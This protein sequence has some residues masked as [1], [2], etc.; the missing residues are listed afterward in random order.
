M[1]TK[2]G[3]LFLAICVAVAFHIGGIFWLDHFSLSFQPQRFEN[4]VANREEA[5]EMW[6]RQQR[7]ELLAEIFSHPLDE[8]S[9]VKRELYELKAEYAPHLD[10]LFPTDIQYELSESEFAFENS[11]LQKAESDVEGWTLGAQEGGKASLLAPLPRVASI[12]PPPLADLQFEDDPFDTFG[13]LAGSEHFDIQVEYAPKKF[14]PGYVFKVTFLPRSDVQF[15]RI[16]QNFFFLLDRSNSITRGRY[17]LNKRAVANALNFL[18]PGDC[19]NILVF[20]DHVVRFRPDVVEWSEETLAE[21]R[22]FLESQN[23]GGYFAATELYASLGKII[24][25]DVAEDEINSA[26]LLSDG[27]TYLSQEKQRLTI[28][29]WTA[30]NKGKV[31]LYSV[32]SGTGNNLPLLELLSSFNKGALIYAQ[33]HQGVGDRLAYL[34]RTLQHPIGKQM[35]ATAVSEDKS[36]TILLQP[37]QGRIPDLYQHRPFVIFGSTNKLS[38]FVLFLQG[39]YYE[40]RFD[41]KKRISFEKGKLDTYSVERGWTQLVVQEFYERYFEEG[42]LAH[43]EAAKQLLLPLNLPTPLME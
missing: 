13:T 12:H 38:D 3:F 32:A 15:K 6:Q 28:G 31:S 21:T 5:F 2:P 22:A 19:F 40:H 11:L 30:Q 16:R 1:A 36:M 14:R 26:I 43:L 7:S 37:K 20:D 34:M 9:E 42:N 4:A 24:P 35:V 41:I 33:D 39:R 8:R 17:L 29:R 23:H 10:L 18:K 27:D 25:Q